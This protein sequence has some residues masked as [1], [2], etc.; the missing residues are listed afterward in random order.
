MKNKN[1]FRYMTLAI[2]LVG[3]FSSCTDDRDSNPSQQLAHL[4][5]SSP[6]MPIQS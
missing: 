6:S 2:G 1:I 3:L 5:S 4:S